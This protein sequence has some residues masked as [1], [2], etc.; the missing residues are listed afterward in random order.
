MTRHPK[1]PFYE[2]VMHLLQKRK[3]FGAKG[4]SILQHNDMKNSRSA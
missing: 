2:N 1:Y 3:L 4:D